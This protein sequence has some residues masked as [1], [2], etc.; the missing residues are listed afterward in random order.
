M[1]RLAHHCDFLEQEFASSSV[2]VVVRF[3]MYF[4]GYGSTHS[5]QWR[6]RVWSQKGNTRLS[7]L[8]TVTDVLRFRA[9]KNI[10]HMFSFFIGNQF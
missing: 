2:V 7:L 10:V 9:G 6:R 1:S 3:E 4:T 5:C 8:E